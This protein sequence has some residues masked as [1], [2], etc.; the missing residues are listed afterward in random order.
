MLLCD[1]HVVWSVYILHSWPRGRGYRLIRMRYAYV[2]S[3]SIC[4]FRLRRCSRRVKVGVIAPIY[5]SPVEMPAARHRP[6]SQHQTH[7][8]LFVRSFVRCDG[9]LRR[10]RLTRAP[11]STSDSIRLPDADG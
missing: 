1:N 8:R 11:R 10:C 2:Y 6:C 4:T 7:G 9:D 5:L 3:A